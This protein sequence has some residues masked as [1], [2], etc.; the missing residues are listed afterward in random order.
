MIKELLDLNHQPYEIELFR[1]FWAMRPSYLHLWLVLCTTVL[2]HKLWQF[3][4]WN[5]EI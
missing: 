4:P 5:S 2:A 1:H 3:V